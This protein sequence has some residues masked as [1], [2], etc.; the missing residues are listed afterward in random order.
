[1][2]HLV[3]HKDNPYE[4]KWITKRKRTKRS[5]LDF[6]PCREEEQDVT[7]VHLGKVQYNIERAKGNLPEHVP[8]IGEKEQGG[9]DYISD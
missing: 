5:K 3:L 1:M 6:I 9:D 2:R 4:K 7:S 8:S